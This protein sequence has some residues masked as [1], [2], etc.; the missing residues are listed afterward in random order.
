MYLDFYYRSFVLGNLYVSNIHRNVLKF[1]KV[2]RKGFNLLDVERNVCVINRHFY[3][4]LFAN[5]EI[6]NGI[7]YIEQVRIP[8]YLLL[9][10][11]KDA[12]NTVNNK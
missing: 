11:Y 4:R 8:Q 5:I 1:I 2:T 3:S 9:K 10:D 6:P 7:K 12:N